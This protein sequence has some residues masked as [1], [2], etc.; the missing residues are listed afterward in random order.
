MR[1]RVV[2]RSNPESESLRW[3][4]MVTQG[5][6]SGGLLTQKLRKLLRWLSQGLL[7]ERQKSRHVAGN[8]DLCS[9]AWQEKLSA[10]KVTTANLKAEL[11]KLGL[12]TKGTKV[13][14]TSYLS[15]FFSSCFSLQEVLSSRLDEA[16]STIKENQ[17]PGTPHTS[18]SSRPATPPR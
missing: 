11:Q 18:S 12:S 17:V 4:H 8:F 10:P 1:S 9:A 7:S 6:K 16:R 5:A 15:L 2:R 13:K 14:L 3:I